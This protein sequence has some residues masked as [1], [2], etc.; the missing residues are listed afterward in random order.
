MEQLSLRPEE[1]RDMET[2]TY[3]LA[4]AL[5]PEPMELIL[6]EEICVLEKRL[7]AWVGTNRCVAVSDA[8]SGMALA[9]LAAGIGRGDRV[10]CAALGCALPVQGI[11]LAGASPV[12]ADINPNTY[13]IDPFCLEYVLGNLKRNNEPP[14]R[15][16]IAT[17][18]FGAPCHYI[19]LEKIC[20]SRGMALIEDM[21]GAF[22]AKY[23]GRPAG[24]FGRFSVASFAS[25]GPLE[26]MGGG[27][28]FCRDPDDAQSVASLR[29]INRQQHIEPGNHIPF[30][31]SADAA[32]TKLRLDSL[33]DAHRRRRKAANHY[34]RV[35]TGKLR[36]QQVVE[37]GES[38][39][40]Q[41]VVALPKAGNRAVVTKRLFQ[42]NIPAGPP[43][44]GMQSADTA[45]NRTMLTNTHALS[46]RL[47]SLPIH[48]HLNGPTVDFI[49]DS[50]LSAM[51]AAE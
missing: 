37:E 7:A 44:C 11:L 41:L 40:S 15:A 47:L 45:W 1:L 38:V 34:R 24:N 19:E 33:R 21:S 28:V 9:L 2:G 50:L 29:R 43:L 4:E 14:P 18:L 20:Q 25:P 17:D 35:L 26:E 30:M 23:L 32:L 31:A 16:L 5:L 39:Y 10:I 48:S 22:G 27:A 46:G 3:A 12:F 13:T 49:C 8:A 51:G 36:L 42:M 6:G